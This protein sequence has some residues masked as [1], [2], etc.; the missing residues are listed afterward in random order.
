MYSLTFSSIACH[1][2]TAGEATVQAMHS[3]LKGQIA[4]M[5]VA[6][7]AFLDR[8]GIGLEQGTLPLFLST[9]CP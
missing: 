3:R 9:F 8:M 7:L 2:S 4:P 5:E 6:L 1:R